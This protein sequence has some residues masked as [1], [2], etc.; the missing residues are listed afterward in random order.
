M[1]A[2]HDKGMLHR[3]LKPDNVMVIDDP[4]RRGDGAPRSWTSAWPRS[5]PA[6]GDTQPF[7]TRIGTQMGTPEYMA[8]EQ[9]M[10]TAVDARTDVYS[11]GVMLYEMLSGRLPFVAELSF[12]LMAMHVRAEVPPL[13]QA[14]PGAAP[15]LQELVGAMLAKDS[16]LRP[17]WPR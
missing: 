17:A 11:L 3:D 2:A 14:R 6:A 7:K 8:P 12:E 4:V 10:G 13:S 15:E 9:C 5:W 16:S 1:A